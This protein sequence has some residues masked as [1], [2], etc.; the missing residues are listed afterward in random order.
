MMGYDEA[1][2][3]GEEINDQQIKSLVHDPA[4]T[5]LTAMP[6]EV[7]PQQPQMPEM[8]MNH[9]QFYEQQQQRQHM[10][11]MPLEQ[12]LQFEEAMKVQNA[13]KQ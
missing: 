2:D 5:A 1:E 8:Q 10:A 3:Y 7:A 6:L 13:M 12:Q 11:N 9:Q 4:L